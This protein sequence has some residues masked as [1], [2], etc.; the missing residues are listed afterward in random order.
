MRDSF[1]EKQSTLHQ[2]VI[3]Q[4]NALIE[5]NVP[6]LNVIYPNLEKLYVSW[7]V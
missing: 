3:Y 7:F 4:N 6:D 1:L 2:L 5:S